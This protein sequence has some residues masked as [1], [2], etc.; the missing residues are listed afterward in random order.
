[1]LIDTSA[2]REI[3]RADEPSTSMLRIRTRFER[4]GLMMPLLS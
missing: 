2:I 3:E 4:G 1:V